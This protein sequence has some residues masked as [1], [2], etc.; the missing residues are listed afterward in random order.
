MTRKLVAAL[1]PP[2]LATLYRRWRDSGARPDRLFDGDDRLFKKIVGG[3]SVY[4]EYGCGQSTRWVMNHT[5]ATVIAVDT[6]GEWVAEVLRDNT[7]NNDRLD[8]RHVDLGETGEWGRPKGYRR[9]EM[10][11]HYTDYMWDRPQ[12]PD[13]VL[14]D[15]RFRVCC[16]LTSLKYADEGVKIFFDDYTDREHYHIVE[17]YVAR[18]DEC[19]RQALFI[20]PSRDKLNI[21]A[22]ER[23][24]AA[25]RYVMD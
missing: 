15:G 5:S 8:I 9:R 14:V 3:A 11:H 1:T 10:F 6:A 12:K 2:V 21:E 13:V 23:D 17:H 20:V 7:A 22:L 19:G 16:F 24:I 25:F 18:A 4:G